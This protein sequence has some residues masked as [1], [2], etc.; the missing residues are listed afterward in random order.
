MN[1]IPA[2]R[3]SVSLPLLAAG[4]IASGEQMLAAMALG[5]DGVQLGSL[6]ASSKESSAHDEFKKRIIETGEGGTKLVLKQLAP[7]RLIKNEFYQQVEDA[8]KRGASL[9]ELKML[10]GRGRAKQGMFEGD[11]KEG[12]LEI[13]QCASL[14]NNIEPVKVIFERLLDEYNLAY[15]RLYAPSVF[16]K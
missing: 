1:L 16:N 14:I 9:D 13:G 8:E 11:M 15:N 2:V 3:K 6:F 7:V 4:G 5:A 12:E 10:L